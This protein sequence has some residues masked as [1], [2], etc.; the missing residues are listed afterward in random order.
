MDIKS[1]LIKGMIPKFNFDVREFTLI[2]SLVK[3]AWTALRWQTETSSS[4]GRYLGIYWLRSRGQARMGN[5][6]AWELGGPN[7]SPQKNKLL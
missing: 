2:G 1:L 3:T 5:P 6:S 7:N 4:Y